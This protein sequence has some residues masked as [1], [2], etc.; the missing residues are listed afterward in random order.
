MIRDSDKQLGEEKHRVRS[1][2]FPNTGDSVPMEL[3]STTLQ[4]CGW[5]SP[6][7]K[8]LNSITGGYLWR[9]HHVGMIH[10]E[11]NLQPFS[12]SWRIGQWSVGGLKVFK[13]LITSWSFWWQAPGPILKLSRSPPEGAS[14]EA[15]ER[16]SYHLSNFKSLR[17][18]VPGTGVKDQIR[19]EETSSMLVT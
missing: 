15:Q 7:Q 8:I 10:H 13:F 3:G 11:F 12:P 9:F 16:D 4:A 1:E 6:I 5:N 14:L 19:I 18:S 17:S 2:K